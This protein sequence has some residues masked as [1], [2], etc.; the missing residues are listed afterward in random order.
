MKQFFSLHLVIDNS[1]FLLHL[2]INNDYLGY[3]KIFIHLY[4]PLKKLLSSTKERCKET[5]FSSMLKTYL[6]FGGFPRFYH[7]LFSKHSQG[8]TIKIFNR[9]PSYSLWK[10]LDPFPPRFYHQ[11]STCFKGSIFWSFSCVWSNFCGFHK[12]DEIVQINL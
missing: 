7:E 10:N 4:I 3:I 1:H 5:T 2:V 11:I 12:N 6:T 8:S 9:F